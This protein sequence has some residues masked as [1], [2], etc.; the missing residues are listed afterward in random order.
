M[1]IKAVKFTCLVA[2]FVFALA[3]LLPSQSL[4]EQ[5]TGKDEEKPYELN[6]YLR[7]TLFV[8]KVPEKNSMEIKSGYGEAS[9]KLRLRKQDFGD[10]FAEV[11]FR[12]GHEFQKTV[13]EIYLR[14]A[15]VNAYAGPFDFRIG[16]QV[17]VWGRADGW[18]PTDN[19]TPRNML[20]RSPD[21]DDRRLAN[22]LIRSY[23]NLHP[24]RLEAIWIPVYSPS[25]IPTDLVP[26]PA[27]I[28]LGE[29]DY[30]DMKMKNSAFALRLN[31]ELPAID[32]SISY[33]NGHNPMPGIM[34]EVPDI[35][36]PDVVLN[37]FHKSYRMHIIG[38]DFSTVVAGSWGLRGEMAYRRSH[39]DYKMFIH[40]PNP[41][42][43]YVLGL[44]KELGKNFSLIFQYIG[45]YV[46]DFEEL[47][48][49]QNP[50]EIPSYEIALK[51]RLISF[52]QY[53]VSHSLSC[54][55]AWELM[56]ELLSIEVFGLVNFTSNET[57]FRPKMTYD[58]A[59]ALTFSLG[60]ELYSGPDDTL[61]GLVDSTLSAVFMELKASF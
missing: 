28:V 59:D 21:E 24:V 19:I 39:Q 52:Q 57:L 22:F 61:F 56:N 29:P 60:A 37:V 17:V 36:T 16:H 58:I 11:R 35:M 5:A 44:D 23:Y 9:L 38:A 54:R 50:A 34:A 27:G 48:M 46:F 33:F 2:M 26:F 13:S 10:A 18:N 45:R 12:R 25:Y 40:I 53:K 7:G 51:N 3:S 30:P 49:P 15:Y 41:D 31:M 32:G 43:Q 1:K 4:F 8:G 55:A 6:G 20:I 14:E 42:L 47:E